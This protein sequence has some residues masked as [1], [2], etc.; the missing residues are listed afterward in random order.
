MRVLSFHTTPPP[1]LAA[2]GCFGLSLGLGAASLDVSPTSVTNTFRGVVTVSVTGLTNGEPVLLEKF[3]DPN[4]NGV[5]D[6]GEALV[7]SYVLTDG[8][9]A[10]IGGVRNHNVPGDEDGS[11]NGQIT[12]AFGFPTSV[13]FERAIGRY[14]YRVSSPGGRFSAVTKPLAVTPTSYP[15]SV[16]GTITNDSGSTVPFASVGVLG[17]DGDFVA[18]GRADAGGAYSFALAPGAY[19]LIALHPGYVADMSAPAQVTLGAG[20]TRSANLG[21]K[22]GTRTLA[23]RM[24]DAQSGAGLAGMQIFCESDLGQIAISFTDAGGNFSVSVPPGMWTVEPSEMATMLRGYMYSQSRATIDLTAGDVSGAMIDVVRGTSLVYGTVTDDGAQKVAGLLGFCSN[25]PAPLEGSGITDANGNYWV[26]AGPG[27]WWFGFSDDDLARMG[28][29]VQGTNFTLSA[30]QA[31]RVDFTALHAT[32]HLRGV[33]RDSQGAPLGDILLVASANNRRSS[34]RSAGDGSFDLPVSAGT[35]QFG[36]EGSEATARG[37]LSPWLEVTVTDGADLNGLTLTALIV[38]AQISGRVTNNRAQGEA[39]L[40]LYV[41]A[42]VNG[43]NYTADART[44]ASGYY[45]AAVANGTWHVGVPCEAATARGYACPGEQLLVVA[46]A[47]R[48]ADFALA[49]PAPPSFGPPILVGRQFQCT[50]STD[51]GVVCRIAYTS[52]FVT[53]SDLGTFT[54]P[55]FPLVDNLPPSGDRRFYRAE[56]VP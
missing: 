47:N 44:D 56:V 33:V 35:W 6:A 55:S 12:S 48:V 22:P 43:T 41:F 14:L 42:T 54:G 18:G 52:D 40:I 7:A 10:S 46:G 16:S 27:H 31:L 20:E 23:G 5:V 38:T 49:L 25:E 30:S 9:V 17:A 4:D 36:L 15:Q 37:L 2:L 51:P 13:E 21:L 24:R 53:W 29:L 32:A 1:V 45:S 8:Q 3:Q 39:D 26:V 34:T 19:A 50:V 28:L 11:A